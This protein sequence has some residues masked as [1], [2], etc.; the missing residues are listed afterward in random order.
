[1][2]RAIL[3]IVGTVA[4][5]VLLLSFKTHSAPSTASAGATLGTGSGT[6]SGGAAP[7]PSDSSGASAGTGSGTKTGGGSGRTSKST[8]RTVTGSTIDTRWGPVQVQVTLKDGKI[9][10]VQALQL[11]S[12]NRR[13]LEINNFAVPQLYQE[14]LS[15]QS[16]QI[17]AVSGATYTS[18]GY[19]QSLQSALDKA[20][21]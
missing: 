12:G 18:Q 4:G 17:D 2:K 19:I 10:K 5:L 20:G 1:M 6:D 8:T 9:T 11:P 15:A 21:K 13:D 7:A 3:T 16:A 14:T